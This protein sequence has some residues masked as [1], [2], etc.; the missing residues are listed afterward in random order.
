MMNDPHVWESS[1]VLVPEGSRWRNEVA[2]RIAL[3]LA[4]HR[5]GR[6]ASRVSCLL[7]VQVVEGETIISNRAAERTAP[8]APRG[9]LRSYPG[10][11]HFD[12]YVGEGFERLST[13]QLDFLT[14][15]L[16][17]GDMPSPAAAEKQPA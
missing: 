14:R 8:I 7:L 17:R 12:V 2:A 15:H 13:D 6:R 4:S 9:E 16:L 3:R 11:N 5:P 1:R 10:F